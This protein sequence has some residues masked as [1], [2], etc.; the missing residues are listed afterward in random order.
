MTPASACTDAH[1]PIILC[2]GII[3]LDE[4]FRVERFPEPDTKAAAPPMPQSRSR[5]S[6]GGRRSPVR[7]AARPAQMQTVIMCLLRS[8]AKASTVAAVRESPAC[9]P[10]CQRSSSM[11]A[12]IGLS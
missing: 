4:V 12:A 5:D 9:P 3:V 11:R 1:V 6:A 8:R 2:A 7:L 10:L